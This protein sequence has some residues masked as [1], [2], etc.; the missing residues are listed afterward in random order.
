[1]A[2][3]LDAGKVAPR[4]TDLDFTQL[5]TSYGIG[6]RFHMPSATLLRVEVART[7]EGT[8]LVFGFGPVF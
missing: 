5:K 6:I 4:R 1:M 7:G 8:A 3:F 2:L